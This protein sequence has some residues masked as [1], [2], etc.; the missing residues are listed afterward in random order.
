MR[1]ARTDIKTRPRHR[2]AGVNKL[3]VAT[4]D[5]S[6]VIKNGWT[7]TFCTPRAGGEQAPTPGEYTDLV[8]GQTDSS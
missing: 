2:Q 3:A 5:Q 6:Q 1:L 7:A 8:K 4:S